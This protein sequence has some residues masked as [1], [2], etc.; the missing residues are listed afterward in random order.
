[1]CKCTKWQKCCEMQTKVAFNVQE[2]ILVRSQHEKAYLSKRA[3]VIGDRRTLHHE[4]LNLRVHSAPNMIRSIKS[5]VIGQMGDIICMA[6]MLQA[7]Q[8]WSCS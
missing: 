8:V 7:G 3:E 4:E 5:C 2:R 6:K 1:M